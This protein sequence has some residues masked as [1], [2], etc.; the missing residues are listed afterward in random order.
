[1]KKRKIEK[2]NDLNQTTKKRYHI[3]KGLLVL[4]FLM[5]FIELYH[6]MIIKN[7]FFKE[8][9]LTLVDVKT[10]GSSAPRGRIYDRHYRL[11]VDNQAIKKIVYQKPKKITSEEELKMAYALGEHIALDTT[12]LSER[13]VK[14]YIIAK[15]KE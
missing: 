13:N 11:L 3:V 7:D 9:L 15:D 4:F 6:V 8:K 10:E 2:K 5:I 14:D 1:M 12:K